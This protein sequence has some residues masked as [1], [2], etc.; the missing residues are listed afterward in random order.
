MATHQSLQ[1]EEANQTW[2]PESDIGDRGLDESSREEKSNADDEGRG[3]R[4]PQEICCLPTQQSMILMI[5]LGDRVQLWL[6]EEHL[7]VE[8]AARS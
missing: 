6:L 4:S 2:L 1:L 7:A 5:L 3:V 8:E